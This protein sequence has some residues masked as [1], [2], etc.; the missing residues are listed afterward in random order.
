MSSS[1]IDHAKVV[2][3]L[4]Q[5]IITH[6]SYEKLKGI[7]DQNAELHDKVEKL[8]TA[9]DMNLEN[10]HNTKAKLDKYCH[11]LRKKDEQVQSLQKEADDL[12]SILAAK[13]HEL[14]ERGQTITRADDELRKAKLE[15]LNLT[16]RLEEECKKNE[17]KEAIEQELKLTREDLDQ[18][19]EELEILKN[20][21]TPLKSMDAGNIAKRFTKIFD[22][23][24]ELAKQFFGV[25]LPESSI[26]NAALWDQLK[27]HNIVHQARI[28]LPLSNTLPAR[29]MRS[30]AV[31]AVLFAELKKHVFHPTH[32]FEDPR[33]ND[34]FTALLRTMDP[35]KEAYFRSVLFGSIDDDQWKQKVKAKVATVKASV[36]KCVG[37]LLSESERVRFMQHLDRFCR[38]TCQIWQNL[39]KLETKIHYSTEDWA[40]PDTDEYRVLP[41]SSMVVMNS[42]LPDVTYPGEYPESPKQKQRLVGNGQSSPVMSCSNVTFTHDIDRLSDSPSPSRSTIRTFDISSAAAVATTSAAG[43]D[44]LSVVWPAFY[45]EPCIP[46]E[47][48]WMASPGYGVCDSQF[49][50][51]REE[52][53]HLKPPDT[54]LVTT[55]IIKTA[56]LSMAASLRFRLF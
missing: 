14:D 8:T 44:L 39:Q 24:R 55:A 31:L 13:T 56:G 25:D 18:N 37:P 33:A 46:G 47:F 53:A 22:L 40:P 15:I 17:E 9:L 36:D 49:K 7:S 35:A 43:N 30:V 10:L 19:K 28:P 42:E 21:S 3:D 26:A 1:Q 52:E 29:Q 38:R 16:E 11:E 23:A 20:F 12:G 2:A 45:T 27:K 51:A 34:E 41:L 6:T 48:I 4:F 54:D 32:L 50:A 5:D